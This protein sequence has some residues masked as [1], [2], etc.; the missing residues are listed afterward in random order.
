MYWDNDVT[1][2]LS[3][4]LIRSLSLC[5][6]WDGVARC[7]VPAFLWSGGA[8]W[9]PILSCPP[10]H[11]WDISDL[12]QNKS[13][14]VR[15]GVGLRLIRLQP[16]DRGERCLHGNYILINPDLMIFSPYFTNCPEIYV[17][18]IIL[19]NASHSLLM[20]VVSIPHLF[21]VLIAAVKTNTDEY[22][23]SG[24][25][26]LQRHALWTRGGLPLWCQHCLIITQYSQYY[27]NEMCKR[28]FPKWCNEGSRD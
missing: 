7:Q 16:D 19:C 20:R 17:F 2:S 4:S 25:P 3:V 28:E 5:C 6:I 8:N 13:N 14:K 1:P 26:G 27:E 11:C 23:H 10:G 12:S 22:Q 18:Y 15:V 21:A 9:W 24:D